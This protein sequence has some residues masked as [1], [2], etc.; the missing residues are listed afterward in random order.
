MDNDKLENLIKGNFEYVK[1]KKNDFIIKKA[2]KIFFSSTFSG[3]LS[4]EVL[5]SQVFFFLFVR[6]K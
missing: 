6:H 1:N 4:F 5:R 3:I 2:V